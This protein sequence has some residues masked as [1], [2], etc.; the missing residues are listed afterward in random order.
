MSTMDTNIKKTEEFIKSLFE[1]SDY[2]KE[3][4]SEKNYRLEHSY[5]VA[6]IGKEIAEREGFPV[7]ALV[8]GC[9]LH[10][11]SYGMGFDKEEDWINH[12]RSSAKIAREFLEEL[13]L[14]KA[15]IEEICYGIA[16]HVDDKANSDGN[17]TPLA[18]SISEA[19]NIDRF[20]VY[21]IYDNLRYIGFEDMTLKEK[22]EKVLSMLDK[23]IRYKQEKFQTQTATK[24]WNS[25]LDFQIDFYSKLRDQLDN[26]C[27]IQ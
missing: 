23:L 25:K 16:I 5:R 15:V 20:D 14:D 19:D 7:E 11:V 9:L 26:S 12:G 1:K 2:F 4:V 8:I 6:N 18:A 24:L 21:R 22:H 13:D 17:R 27:D 3:H 10:D